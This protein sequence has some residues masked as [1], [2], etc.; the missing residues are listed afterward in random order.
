[1]KGK[2]SYDRHQTIHK[3]SSI[4]FM[5]AVPANTLHFT[6]NAKG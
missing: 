2:V 4:L 6:D 5:L 3:E 1:M